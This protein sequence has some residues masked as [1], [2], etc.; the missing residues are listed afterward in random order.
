MKLAFYIPNK[1]ICEVD[2][3]TVHITNPGIGGTEYAMLALAYYLAKINGNEIVIYSNALLKN[4]PGD[5]ICRIAE[6]LEVAMELAFSDGVQ[7]LTIHHSEHSM[8]RHIFSAL[9]GT[10][11]SV[12]IWIHNFTNTKYLT[13]YNKSSVVKRIVFVGKEFLY[14][15]MDHQ[16]FSKSTYIYNGIT[17]NKEKML[18]YASRPNHVTYIGNLIKGKGFHLLARAW[19]DVLKEVPDAQLHV[20]GSGKLYNRNAT[21]GRFGYADSKY[22]EE[23]M[24]YLTNAKGQQ[25]KSVIFHG[26]MGKEKD[27]IIDMTKV[28]IPNPSGYSET[29]GYTAIE[30]EMRGCLITTAKCPGYLDT[31]YKNGLLCN[32]N[33]E[34][35]HNIIKLLK[36][37]D[38]DAVE[39][40]KFIADNFDFTLVAKKWNDLFNEVANGHSC[41]PRLENCMMKGHKI[42]LR[43]YKLKKKHVWLKIIPS[44]YSINTFFQNLFF[45]S[46]YKKIIKKVL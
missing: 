26:I 44:Y 18:P 31:V 40:L 3:N 35:A 10:N 36:R 38:N 29:F 15:Y 19:K 12:I 28:G 7:C 43:L 9:E 13:Y 25:L 45:Y 22:E 34:L 37:K 33:K 24:K 16:A 5:C 8:K 4:Y 46:T 17:L 27:K 11:V 41:S 42:R 39:M 2:L 1:N 23:F 30:M 20:I 6:N 21:M 32:R 14:L